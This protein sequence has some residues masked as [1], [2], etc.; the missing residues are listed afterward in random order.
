VS[1]FGGVPD[2]ACQKCHDAGPHPARI[3]DTAKPAKAPRCVDCHV[4]H[5]GRGSLAHVR[6]GDCTSCHSDIAGH[7]SGARVKNVSAF[8]EGKHPE[9]STA[10]MSDTGLIKL[11]HAAHMPSSPKTIRGMKLPMKCID[12]HQ[13][14]RASATGDLLPVT[15]ER[16]CKSC[17]ARELEFD[18]YHVLGPNAPPAPHTRNVQQIRDYVAAAY[19]DASAPS[20]SRLGSEARA[21][22]SASDAARLTRESEEFLFTRK[23]VYCHAAPLNASQE[24]YRAYMR[25]KWLDRGEF[26]H[27]A[28]RAVACE[29]CHKA[30]K[31]STKTA[32]V[33]IPKMESCLPCHGE[34]R[35]ELDRCGVCHVYHDRAR[36]KDVERTFGGTR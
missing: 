32:D 26:E 12:C 17:H 2:T 15:F 8:R 14:D 7:A 22:A 31:T 10:S 34:A 3:V 24:Q 21:S 30:A 36:E 28:H 23:C 16:D 33:L 6:S 27:R 20:R 19:R 9:F 25:T 5:Q 29:S 1:A 18:I 35:A 4:E 13:T 11:N